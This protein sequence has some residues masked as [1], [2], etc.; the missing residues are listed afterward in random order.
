MRLQLLLR[1]GGIFVDH[2]AYVV[3]PFDELR[4]CAAAPVLAGFE[5]ASPTP[6]ERKLNPGVLLAARNASFLRLA[7]ASWR[8][9]STAWD[10]ICCSRSYQLH[11][12]HPGLAQPRADLGPLPRFKTRDEYRQHLARTRVV[13]ATALSHR[14]R[15]QELRAA[16]VLRAVRDVVLRAA[17]AS[18]ARDTPEQRACALRASEAI[19]HAF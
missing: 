5:Q 6:S 19:D 13:H 16:G 8:D 17:N 4:R 10:E 1:H 7:L 11:V 9:Y 15:R 12:A 3:R 14:W 2:D 18:A